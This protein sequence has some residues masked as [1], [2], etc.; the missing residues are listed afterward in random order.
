MD[1]WSWTQ[2][3]RSAN[4]DRPVKLTERQKYK[5]DGQPTDRRTTIQV[6]REAGRQTGLQLNGILAADRQAYCD[7]QTESQSSSS[8]YRNTER[9][10]VRH[11]LKLTE[12]QRDKKPTKRT[13]RQIF[14][15]SK[16]QKDGETD[17]QTS[18][19]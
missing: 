17:R 11:I 8:R 3:Y 9:W 5:T 19:F 16:R 13:D 2:T 6:E 1:R 7:G 4:R 18:I 14:K 15:L 10:A 12:R